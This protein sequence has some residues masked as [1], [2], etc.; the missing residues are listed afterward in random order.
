MH[1]Q[2]AAMHRM[3]AK[4]GGTVGERVMDGGGDLHRLGEDEKTQAPDVRQSR[5][6]G[7]GASNGRG[8]DLHR[9]GEKYF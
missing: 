4:A 6:D 8:G 5:G 3:S 2:T 1:S 7:R 9:L